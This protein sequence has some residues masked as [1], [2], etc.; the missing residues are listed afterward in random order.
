MTEPTATSNRPL[1]DALTA[2][3]DH[4]LYRVAGRAGQPALF[5]TRAGIV[6]DTDAV[7]LMVTLGWLGSFQP[8][9]EVDGVWLER[10]DLTGEGLIHVGQ[11]TR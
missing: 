10:I 11:V 8:T 1:S 9:E 4:D 2:A 7:T 5:R 3:A 6:L